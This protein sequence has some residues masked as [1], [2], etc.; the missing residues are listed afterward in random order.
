MSDSATDEAPRYFNMDGS[1]HSIGDTVDC[2]CRDKCPKCG[3][4]LHRQPIWGPGFMEMCEQCDIA[5]STTNVAEAGE[6]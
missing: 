1:R 5:A 3:S 4:R 2:S 6:P